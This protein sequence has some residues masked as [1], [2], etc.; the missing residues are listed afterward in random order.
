MGRFLC[1]LGLHKWRWEHPPL[2]RHLGVNFIRRWLLGEFD[3]RACKR[4]DRVD[5]R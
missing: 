5:L 2:P 4:C 3:Y 1:R